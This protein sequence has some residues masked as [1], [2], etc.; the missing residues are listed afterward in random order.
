[1]KKRFRI[2]LLVCALLLL[3]GCSTLLNRE[4]RSVS[5]HISHTSDTEDTSALQAETYSDLVNSVQFF[6]SMGETEGVVHL[7][8]YSGNVEEDVEKVCQEVLTQDPLGSWALRDIQWTSSRIVSYDECVFTFSYRKDPE[9]I[10]ALRSLVGSTSIREALEGTL[11]RFESSLSIQTTPYYARAELILP[12]VQEAYYNLPGCALGYPDVTV[13][14]YPQESS[15][16]QPIVE[17]SLSYSLSQSRLLTQSQKVT[18]AAATLTG[19]SPAQGEVGYWLLYS[20]LGEQTSF[21]PGGSASV[22]DA[23]VEGEAGSEGIALAYQL[24]C[25]QA[26]LTCMT[27]Q[28]TLDGSPHW[29][30]LVQ[31]EDTWRHVDVTA[32]LGQE[33]FLR[34]DGQMAGQY[35]WDQESYPACPDPEDAPESSDPSSTQEDVDALD[36][37]PAEGE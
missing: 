18:A 7:Y 12:L 26:G 3:T 5:R 20:R 14:I 4:Y 28:G 13:D 21:L 37:F 19:P 6:V 29:W 9:E 36:A 11:S 23:L 25:E 32:G 1:M 34:S 8:R 35:I 16:T 30:N 24:L 2:P 15:G 10:A 27:V 31:A 33:A 22:Y 17:I